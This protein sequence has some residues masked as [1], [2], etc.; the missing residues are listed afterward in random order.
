M[1]LW[2]KRSMGKEER[3]MGKEENPQAKPL[4]VFLF[5]LICSSSDLI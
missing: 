5:P 2:G 1:G 3:S 4:V